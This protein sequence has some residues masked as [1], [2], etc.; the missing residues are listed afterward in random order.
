MRADERDLRRYF[1][2]RAGC[3]VNDVIL[4]RDRRTG[5][6]KGCAYVELGRLEDVPVAVERHNGKVPDFQRFPILVRASEA[7]K[8]YEEE[9]ESGEKREGGASSSVVT[10]SGGGGTSGSSSSATAS[11]TTTTT[12]TLPAPL[13][14]KRVQAQSI[15]VGSIDRCVTQ[16]QLYAIF[17]QFGTL[18]SPVGLQIDPTTG[19]SRG[20]AFL[21][22][23]DA[24]DANLAIQ[25]MSGQKLAGRPLKTGWANHS[26]A[27]GVEAVTSDEFPE[28]SAARIQK[29][30]VVLTQLTG[31]GLMAMASTAQMVLKP[32]TTVTSGTLMTTTTAIPTA[33]YNMPNVQIQAEA[34]LNAALG[35]LPTGT[36]EESSSKEMATAAVTTSSSTATATATEPTTTTTTA[37][38]SSTAPVQDAKEIKGTP[39]LSILVHNMFDKDEETDEGWQDDIREDFVEECQKYGHIQKCL[40]KHQ[41]PGGKIYAFFDSMDS[42]Q[43]CALAMAGRW[44]DKRQLRVEYVTKEEFE[45]EVNEGG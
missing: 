29:A 41:E 39:T 24:K 33:A 19:M 17:S 14:Q 21:S 12:T 7:Q 9:E 27:P 6:H 45:K 30:H 28:D 13:F 11:A 20:F 16:A 44:F 5:R 36:T 25:T 2:R 8:N 43:N 35:L 10:S 31:T 38:P 3:K 18:D 40:V 15:Y 23:H 32:P 1:R 22:F 37:S 4:L 34:A 26:L 42:A